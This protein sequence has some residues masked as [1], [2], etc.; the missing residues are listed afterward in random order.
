[1]LT[2]APITALVGGATSASVVATGVTRPHAVVRPEV[3]VEGNKTDAARSL[4]DIF[5]IGR[6]TDE[7]PFPEP[8]IVG[9][10]A[11][12]RERIAQAQDVRTGSRSSDVHTPLP[13]GV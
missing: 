7:P 13:S 11:G 12:W 3:V 1:M 10:A 4:Y 8:R 2:V 9:R 6:R 5:Q